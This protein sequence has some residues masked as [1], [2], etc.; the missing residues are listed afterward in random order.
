MVSGFYR[1]DVVGLVLGVIFVVV[2]V[3][4]VVVEGCED[5]RWWCWVLLCFFVFSFVNFFNITEMFFRI[6]LYIVI[7]K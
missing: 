5:D 3:S 7:L 6:F 1:V 2:F 4:M